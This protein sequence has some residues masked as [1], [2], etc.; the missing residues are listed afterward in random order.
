[1]LNL[2][3]KFRLTAMALS[4]IGLCCPAVSSADSGTLQFS[5][6]TFDVYEGDGTV[7]IEVTRTGGS[8]GNVSVDYATSD[9]TATAGADYRA[10]SRVLKWVDGDMEPKTFEVRIINDRESNE[11]YETFN[12]ELTEP[13]GGA[14]L[15]DPNEATVEITDN[16]ECGPGVGW[17]NGCPS[18]FDTANSSGTFEVRGPDCRGNG[19][20]MK[21]RGPTTIFRGPEKDDTIQT[22]MVSLELISGDGFTVRAGDGMGNLEN[23]GPLYSPG[24]II[25]QDSDPALADSFFDVYFEIETPDGFG[26]ETPDGKM[27]FPMLY[28]QEPCHMESVID[29]VPPLKVFEQNVNAYTCDNL[30][31]YLSPDPSDSSDPVACL[32][33]PKHRLSVTL[34]YFTA[35]A[36]NGAVALEW[37]TG[38]EKDNAGFKVWRAKPLDGKC[39]NDQNNYTDV[40]AITP[41]VYSLG[42]EVSG[43]TYQITDNNVVS[44]NSYCYALQDI[45]Y[46]GGDSTFHMDDIVS[47]TP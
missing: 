30:L 41:L 9:G 39:S 27:L 2:G 33:H 32:I 26:I 15:G 1:M 5:Q 29:R 40:Q 16:T 34:D 11:R 38:T 42:T 23:D 46:D 10:K 22:E 17:V 43:A 37:A 6:A 13:T 20:K 28:N 47:A 4:T 12:I 21:L 14:S 24:A 44:G 35:T 18:G 7:T 3:S 19:L 8:E 25:E 36:S 31:L 45:E